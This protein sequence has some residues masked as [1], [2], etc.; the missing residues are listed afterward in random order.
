MVVSTVVR[1]S[2]VIGLVVLFAS[3]W[4]YISVTWDKEMEWILQKQIH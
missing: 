2:M 1:S 3:I 4:Q